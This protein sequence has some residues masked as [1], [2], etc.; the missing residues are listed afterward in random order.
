MNVIITMAGRG[1]RFRDAGYNVPKYEIEVKGRT[2]FEWSMRS[3]KNFFINRFI[4]ITLAENESDCF[5]KNECKKIGIND[6]KIEA[7]EEVT[8]G[9]AL[10]ALC[11][12]PHLLGTNSPILIYNIDTYVEPEA[13]EPEMIKG[14][15]WVPAFRAPGSHW[16]FVKHDSELRVTEIVEKVRISD[17]A[18]IG[19]YYFDSFVR[20]ETALKNTSFSGYKE[21]FVAPLY[22]TMLSLVPPVYTSIVPSHKVHALGTPAEVEQFKLT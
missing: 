9:Q 11:A 12:K 14:S 22:S 8:A 15:G 2:L 6:F 21:S 1:S 4:F 16:S 5:I 17:L 18:T 19:L 20:F 7:L 13:L 10:T 3:L